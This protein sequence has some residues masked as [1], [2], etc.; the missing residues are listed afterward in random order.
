M[1]FAGHYKQE[2]CRTNLRHKSFGWRRWFPKRIPS[3]ENRCAPTRTGGSA[4]GIPYRRL[5][6]FKKEWNNLMERCRSGLTGRSRKPLCAYAYRGFESPSLRKAQ[7]T[8]V[9][10]RVVLFFDRPKRAC[11]LKVWEKKNI[12]PNGV[13]WALQGLPNGITTTTKEWE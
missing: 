9:K 5:Q 13:V 10:A 1:T 3:G 7:T 12:T 2:R 4:K 6:V 11:S 8:L